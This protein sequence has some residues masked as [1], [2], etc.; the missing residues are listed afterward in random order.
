[1][2][3]QPVNKKYIVRLAADERRQ[4]ETLIRSSGQPARV[5]SHARILLKVDAGEAGPAWSDATTAAATEVDALTVSRT[6]QRFVAGG[7]ARALYRKPQERRVTPRLDGVGEAHLVALVCGAP[8]EGRA[9]WTLRLLAERMV[10]LGH[11]E[12]L[13]H[14]TVRQA[15]KRGSS[16]R[17]N[18]ATGAS[19][20]H[21][22]GS[23]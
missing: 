11:T 13:S 7:L 6:R 12:Q 17:G 20:R 19:R 16:S 8:P 9:H 2:E 21:R 5:L 15:L 4:L 10:V 3:E 23:S 1:V 22:T 18:S 14:E